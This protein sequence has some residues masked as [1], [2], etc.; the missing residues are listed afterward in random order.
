MICC[1]ISNFEKHKHKLEKIAY[2]EFEMK[3]IVM[4]TRLAYPSNK[5]KKK[6]KEEDSDYDTARIGRNQLAKLKSLLRQN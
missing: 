1:D 5:T 4:E 3:N 2:E 6:S